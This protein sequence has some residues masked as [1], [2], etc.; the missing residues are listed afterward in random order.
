MQIR[1]RAHLPSK[2]KLWLGAETATFQMAQLQ[3]YDQYLQATASKLLFPFTI[4]YA[5]HG[6]G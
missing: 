6:Q 3:V 1:N 4:C 5:V 2:E